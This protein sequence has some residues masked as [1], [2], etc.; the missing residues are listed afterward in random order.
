M[1]DVAGAFQT[2]PICA[3]LTAVLERKVIDEAAIDAVLGTS[4]EL[5][6]FLTKTRRDDARAVTLSRVGCVARER[7]DSRL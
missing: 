4:E 6:E 5:T 2:V 3:D 1:A 7:Q